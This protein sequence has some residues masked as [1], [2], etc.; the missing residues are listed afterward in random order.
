VLAPGLAADNI[1]ICALYFTTIFAIAAR[2]PAEDQDH[3]VG[4]GDDPAAGDK[5]QLRYHP[6]CR[7]PFAMCKAGKLA[8][9]VL[10]IPRPA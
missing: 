4:V 8:T 2:I 5:Q 7:A 1:I 3:S 9:T 10:S 6:L